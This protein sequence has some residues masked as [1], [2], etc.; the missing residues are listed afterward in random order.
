LFLKFPLNIYTKTNYRYE[1]ENGWELCKFSHIFSDVILTIPE[2][3]FYSH[4]SF[5][6]KIQKLMV[7]GSHGNQYFLRF[8][9]DHAAILFLFL[10]KG[11]KKNFLV[12]KQ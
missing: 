7:F 12:F 3:Y 5:G 1:F 4:I 9:I 10:E 2:G 6:P 8:S 11:N